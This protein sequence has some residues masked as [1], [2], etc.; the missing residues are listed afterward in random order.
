[1]QSGER[2]ISG[3]ILEITQLY[4]TFNL[5]FGNYDSIANQWEMRRTGVFVY[6]HTYTVFIVQ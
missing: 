5:T 1:M 4:R 3:H 2:K 6:V